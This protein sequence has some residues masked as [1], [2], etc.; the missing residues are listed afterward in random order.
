M[1]NLRRI[2]TLLCLLG[3]LLL[4]GTSAARAG[5]TPGFLEP[6]RWWLGLGADH[7]YRLHF[8]QYDLSRRFA[9]GGDDQE[10]KEAEFR[11][12]VFTMATLAY[13]LSP[14]VNLL[15]RVGLVDGGKWLDE[16][17]ADGEQWQAKLGRALA[18]A[19]GVRF[20]PWRMSPEGPGVLLSAWYL[21]YDDRPVRQWRNLSGGYAADDYWNTEDEIDY[22]QLDLQALAYWPLGLAVPYAGVGYT[23][24]HLE[25]EG[26]W[27]ARQPG[28]LDVSYD[29]S[30][31]ER[32][33]LTLL[34]GL[35]LDL[36]QHLF[37][38][39][40]GVFVARSQVSLGLAY[41]F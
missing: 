9:G 19:L 28:L 27:R 41:R 6:G 5:G 31:E 38:D 13:G 16:R 23:R 15:A 22:W 12:D 21:R 20:C 25:Q 7:L 26:S 11:D 14:R 30:L 39:L 2:A 35:E 40:R 10:K 1:G 34:L 29:S 4:V 32:E 3:L 8:D 18:W 36:G 33:N 17:V 37:M 24:F